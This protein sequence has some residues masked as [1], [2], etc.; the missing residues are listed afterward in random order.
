MKKI[1]RILL[2]I[3]ITLVIFFYAVVFIPS[4]NPIGEKLLGIALTPFFDYLATIHYEDE[5]ERARKTANGEEVDLRIGRDTC[6]QWENTYEIGKYG[7]NGTK[8]LEV[9][10]GGDF[11]H[12]LSGVED[13]SVYENNSGKM[14]FVVSYEGYA[15]IEENRRCRIYIT[16]PLEDFEAKKEY[17]INEKGEKMMYSGKKENKYVTYLDSFSEY[18]K[19]EQSVLLKMVK[20]CR[21][22]N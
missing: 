16:V 7:L 14:L 22:A 21:K 13:Y 15:V 20:M 1:K 10:K 11:A 8:V 4:L 9:H 18:S 2:G 19:D 12:L 6:Y 3:F 5:V 17:G